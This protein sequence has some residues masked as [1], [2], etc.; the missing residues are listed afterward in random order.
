MPSALTHASNSSPDPI[1]T[2]PVFDSIPFQFTAPDAFLLLSTI[3]SAISGCPNSTHSR[4]K[5]NPINWSKVQENQDPW[6]HL[7]EKW[8]H[9]ALK[10]PTIPAIPFPNTDPSFISPITSPSD[11]SFPL[12]PSSE[13]IP[14]W[15]AVGYTLYS[16]F[17]TPWISHLVHCYQFHNPT[18]ALPKNSREIFTVSSHLLDDLFFLS[19][20][21][22]EINCLFR[23]LPCRALSLAEIVTLTIQTFPDLPLSVLTALKPLDED[24]SSDLGDYNQ[25]SYS[26]HDPAAP[27]LP[28]SPFTPED[29]YSPDS[30]YPPPPPYSPYPVYISVLI[31]NSYIDEQFYPVDCP[32]GRYFLTYYALDS[33]SR[34]LNFPSYHFLEDYIIWLSKSRFDVHREC[35]SRSLHGL[36]RKK[37]HKFFGFPSMNDAFSI[38]KIVEYVHTWDFSAVGKSLIIDCISWDMQG[39]CDSFTCDDLDYPIRWPP[40]REA[41]YDT[42]FAYYLK[43]PLTL[44]KQFV[45]DPHSLTDDEFGRLVYEG[46][47]EVRQFLQNQSTVFSPHIED[48]IHT[49]D[50]RL[51]VKVQHPHHMFKIFL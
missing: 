47:S 46:S 35:F 26:P 12:I 38:Q 8:P 24:N 23:H 48:L 11:P 43:S 17:I 2:P 28:D 44:A 3:I 4:L 18:G 7:S 40:E 13:T 9:F 41:A 29:P 27:Y 16:A 49:I 20:I 50:A 19:L 31:K 5:Q 30:L 22:R 37:L 33:L 1:F 51:T 15:S 42:L 10:Y 45:L 34:H 32:K 36:P 21:H 39:N 14:Y 6:E 25:D